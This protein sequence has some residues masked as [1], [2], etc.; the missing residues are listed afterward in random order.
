MNNREATHRSV[1]TDPVCGM[2][3]DLDG[4]HVEHDG[5]TYHFCS[6]RCRDRFSVDP[7]TFTRP[8][9]HEHTRGHPQAGQPSGVPMPGVTRTT[10]AR[11]LW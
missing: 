7:D 4:P 9:D 1:T 3:V 11:V 2:T 8:H 6:D 5:E 10:G